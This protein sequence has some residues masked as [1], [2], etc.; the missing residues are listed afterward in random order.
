V[1]AAVEVGISCLAAVG[2]TSDFDKHRGGGR[3]G[4]EA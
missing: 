4:G 1:I 3:G 2:R